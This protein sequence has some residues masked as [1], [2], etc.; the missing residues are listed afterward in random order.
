MTNL[1]PQ[2]IHYRVSKSPEEYTADDELVEF[3]FRTFYGE[4]PKGEYNAISY[5]TPPNSPTDDVIVLF[6]PDGEDGI[7]DFIVLETTIDPK[8]NPIPSLEDTIRVY[9][10]YKD[11]F[12]YMERKQKAHR[13][14]VRE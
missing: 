6:C 1:I 11:A 7:G 2:H 12:S 10:S 3:G 5:L 4:I 9:N 13:N 8:G 14:G